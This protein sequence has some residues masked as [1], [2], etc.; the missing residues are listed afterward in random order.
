MITYTETELKALDQKAF[1]LRKTVLSMIH[2]AGSGHTG[3]SLSAV[4]ILSALYFKALNVSAEAPD[5][6]DRDRFILSK[7]HAAPILYAVLAECGYIDKKEL[8]TLRQFGSILQGHPCRDKVPGVE[9]ST[10]SLGMGISAGIGMALAAKVQKKDYKVVVLCGDGEMDEGQNW[11]AF[12]AANK[13]QPDNLTVIIDRNR[14]QLD[15][16]EEEIM[17]T[18]DLSEKIRAFGL[19]TKEI[20]GHSFAQILDALN[21]ADEPGTG[22]SVIIAN[23]IKGKGVPFMEGKNIWHGKTIG[24]DDFKIIRTIYGGDGDEL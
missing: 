23:T 24:D 5:D 11:E 3:G 7:G 2:K 22:T 13:W 14:V 19:R 21:W 12:M 18:G 16:T 20:D 17:P 6:P 1:E 15:G 9:L 8:G 4:E 10:G